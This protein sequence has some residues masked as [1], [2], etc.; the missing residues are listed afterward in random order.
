M[1][2]QKGCLCLLVTMVMMFSL[3]S[4]CGEQ[5]PP[6]DAVQTPAP[7]E[8]GTVDTAPS[9]TPEEKIDALS[10]NELI[11]EELQLAVSL[12]FS[13]EKLEQESINGMEYAELLDALVGYA[14]PGKL[15]EW[16]KQHKVL[17]SYDKPL[18][19]FDAM[20]GLY[21]AALTIGGDYDSFPRR[22]WEFAMSLDH[23]WDHYYFSGDLYNAEDMQR[24]TYYAGDF[25]NN[26]Y[27]DGACYSFN[28]AHA[29]SVSGQHPFSYDVQSNSFTPFVPPTYAECLL[30]V[31]R[32][33]SSVEPGLWEYKPTE[34]EL[35]YIDMAEERREEIKNTVTDCTEGVTGTVYYI[36]NG[37][38]D[39]ND[40]KTPETAWATPTPIWSGV[41]KS[42]DAVLF[43]RGGEWYF[44][45]PE[46]HPGEAAT[47]ALEILSIKYGSIENIRF[48]A[49]GEGEKPIIRGDIPEASDPSFWE[50]YSDENGVK[51]WKSTQELKTV[52]VVAFDE[53]ES[54]ADAVLPWIDGIGSFI[55]PDGT[56]FVLEEGLNHDLTFV[57]LPKLTDETVDLMRDDRRFAYNG[58]TA[59]VYLRCDAGNPAEVYSTV[60]LPQTAMPFD[61]G[62]GC[63]LYD[64][65][66]RF[67]SMHAG[68]IYGGNIEYR[69]L[70]VGWCGGFLETY[71]AMEDANGIYGYMPQIAGGGLYISNPDGVTVTDCH[72]HDCAPMAT[73]LSMHGYDKNLKG[74]EVWKDFYFSDNLFER[75]GASGHIADF[76]GIDTV[77]GEGF[78]SNYVFEDN[79]VMRSGEGWGRGA[80]R[81]SNYLGSASGGWL[82]AVENEMSAGDN[83]GIIFRNNLF[84]RSS[85]ALFSLRST[86]LHN[87]L[88]VNADPIFEGN[89]YVQ[90]VSLPLLKQDMGARIYFP[91]EEVVRDILGD[92]TGTLVILGGE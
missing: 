65:S 58:V 8:T 25:G 13:V 79:Y 27:L 11:K 33:I 64:L 40:G 15:D 37:G 31:V 16:Q 67:F 24:N 70:E 88:P 14:A 69:N 54:W 29:S 82:A 56:P 3:F 45:P 17:R 55:N 91:S 12:G 61:L 48:G 53:G 81:Q 47:I 26:S 7:T 63:S 51:I 44:K 9:I 78:L 38:N 62:N 4:G 22:I 84:F 77:T 5:T 46:G 72:V 73:I 42:G 85:Y 89:T 60:S 32:L 21:L 52:P 59:P 74:V 75:C 80:I 20:A 50:L 66:I 39:A 87:N 23:S 1:K 86:K 71:N 41:L 76:V 28:M 10:A 2:T 30:A 36:S 90:L 57:W 83:D 49:Y 35:V 34:T 18:E 92:K 43:E 68:N 19:R 6:A